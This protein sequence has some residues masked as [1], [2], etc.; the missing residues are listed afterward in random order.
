[1]TER[2]VF[3][4]EM[5]QI[6]LQICLYHTLRTFSREITMDKM[7]ITSHQH[8]T[9]LKILEKLTYSFDEADYQQIYE[10][11]QQEVPEKVVEY[12]NAN[13]HSIRDEWVK[14]LKSYHLCNDTTN[15]VESFS[16]NLKKIFPS[17]I[18]P[19]RNV[20]WLDELH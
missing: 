18:F 17:M 9:A 11:F 4:A 20:V 19:E 14:G 2:S 12:F 13:W 16:A 8:T 3:K 5:S 6:Q 1:M 15:R 10:K 7:A